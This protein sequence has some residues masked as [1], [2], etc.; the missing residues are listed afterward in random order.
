M[1]RLNKRLLIIAVK[2]ALTHAAQRRQLSGCCCACFLHGWA[3]IHE[4]CSTHIHLT[5]HHLPPLLIPLLNPNPPPPPL[6]IS[7]H[8]EEAPGDVSSF[9]TQRRSPPRPQRRLVSCVDKQ[10][11]ERRRSGGQGAAAGHSHG[12]QHVCRGQGE[13]PLSQ[14][15]AQ[16]F[17]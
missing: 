7:G 11:V 9:R 12:A 16:H 13:S 8:Q 14:A 4:F 15:A 2:P 17:F 1:H 3:L 6:P 5:S 10:R